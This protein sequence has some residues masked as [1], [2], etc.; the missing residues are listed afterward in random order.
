MDACGRF[1]QADTRLPALKRCVHGRFAHQSSTEFDAYFRTD[2]NTGR[3][4]A[5]ASAEEAALL[6]LA[7]AS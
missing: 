6:L 4:L 3:G 1:I 5:F 2:L 7:T